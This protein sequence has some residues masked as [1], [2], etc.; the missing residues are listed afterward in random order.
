MAKWRWGRR[1]FLGFQGTAWG[2][3]ELP[4]VPKGSWSFKQVLRENPKVGK[5]TTYYGKNTTN[6]NTPYSQ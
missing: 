5:N 4:K 2:F 1:N 6:T 3:K